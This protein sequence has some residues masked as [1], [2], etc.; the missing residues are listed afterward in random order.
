[1]GGN[2]CPLFEA[3]M[4]TAVKERINDCQGSVLITDEE[5]VKRVNRKEIPSLEHVLFVKDIE[6]TPADR[7]ET[8]LVEWVD[9]AG[10]FL[11]HYTSGSTGKPR[12]GLRAP[13]AIIHHDE[14]GKRVLDGREADGYCGAAEPV[15]IRGRVKRL[16]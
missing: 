1:M 2:A 5:L 6:H 4:E 7:N 12:G 13:R 8:E 10:G 3:F 15:G 14:S 16:W 9:L 11:I